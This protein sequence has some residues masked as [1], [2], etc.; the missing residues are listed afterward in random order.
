MASASSPGYRVNG[1]QASV[2]IEDAGWNYDL[3]ATVKVGRQ[4]IP[5]RG[6]KWRPKTN[7]SAGGDLSPAEWSPTMR[8]VGLALIRAA[9]S[10]LGEHLLSAEAVAKWGPFLSP[11]PQIVTFE[12]VTIILDGP[13][14]RLYCRPSSGEGRMP[15][16]YRA[17]CWQGDRAAHALFCALVT[18]EDPVLLASLT[19]SKQG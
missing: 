8:L 13:G 4:P 16:F 9:V 14:V 18:A 11:R 10:N 17:V 6:E 3:L 7:S 15:G 1:L 5:A 19:M 2:Q 12:D